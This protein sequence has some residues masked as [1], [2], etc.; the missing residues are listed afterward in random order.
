MPFFLH[1]RV[2][3]IFLGATITENTAVFAVRKQLLTQGS[4][5]HG[6]GTENRTQ[7]LCPLSPGNRDVTGW[8][9]EVV[10]LL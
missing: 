10:E 3:V 4:F 9:G 6:E 8:A 1:K 5:L 7:S 2:W